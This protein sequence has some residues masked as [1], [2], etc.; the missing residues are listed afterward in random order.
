MTIFGTIGSIV[1]SLIAFFLNKILEDNKEAH[2]E[3]YGDIK[4]LRYDLAKMNEELAKIGLVSKQ[5]ITDE[6]KN[7]QEK[8]MRNSIA[9]VNKQVATLKEDV[10]QVKNIVQPEAMDGL[11]LYEPIPVYLSRLSKKQE[12]LED[13]NNQSLKVLRKHNEL[14][15]KLKNGHLALADSIKKLRNEEEGKDDNPFNR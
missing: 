4:E 15:V 3:F 5:A 1:L 10:T 6:D 13:F 2:R 9:K 8:R 7:A 12:E 11:I 14:I